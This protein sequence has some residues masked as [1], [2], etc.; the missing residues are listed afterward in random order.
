MTLGRLGE[1]GDMA[2]PAARPGPLETL[3][4]NA[5]EHL[6]DVDALSRKG[7]ALALTAAFGGGR[8]GRSE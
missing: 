7:Q 1:N 3:D 4:A 2:T 5:S 6:L 8:N